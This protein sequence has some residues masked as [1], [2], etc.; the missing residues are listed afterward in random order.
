MRVI[1]KLSRQKI[2]QCVRCSLVYID[3]QRIDL[4]NL[5]NKNYYLKSDTNM[6]ANYSDYRDQEKIVKRNFNFAY[7]YVEKNM[8]KERNKLLDIGAGFGYFIKNLPDKIVSEAVEVSKEAVEGLKV[9]TK[10]KIHKGDFLKVNIKSKFNFIVSYDVIEHQN[11][12]TGYLYKIKSLLEDNG[13]VILTTPDFGSPINKILGKKAPLIQ[14]FYHN[15]YFTKEWFNKNMSSFGYKIISIKTSYL[16][17]SSVGNIFLL[18]SFSFPFFRKNFI[19]KIIK[20]LK[21]YN[22]TVPFFRYG[23]IECIMQKI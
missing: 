4:E 10:A 18:G 3:K 14:P 2:V 13:V 19:F 22:I 12:L 6:L 9:N 8:N 7:N 20:F 16:A 11:D 23:G 17:K 15:Y 1:Y 5:Y 21:I